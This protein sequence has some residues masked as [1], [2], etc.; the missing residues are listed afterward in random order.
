M[1]LS[2]RVSLSI[3]WFNE[4]ASG[5]FKT[6]WKC[7][8]HPTSDP[9]QDLPL[10]GILSPQITL[11]SMGSAKSL[12]LNTCSTNSR[13]VSCEVVGNRPQSVG[14]RI[15]KNKWVSFFR[16]QSWPW[17]WWGGVGALCHAIIIIHTCIYPTGLLSTY[18]CQVTLWVLTDTCSHAVCICL[19]LWMSV[20]VCMCKVYRK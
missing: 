10:V 9:L 13:A 17:W 5:N 3:K 11:L 18:W 19:C 15:R 1:S 14:C 12:H 7:G 20:C 8:W 16:V 2:H 4:M 6:L